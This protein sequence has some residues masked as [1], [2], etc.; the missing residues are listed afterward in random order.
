[1]K[2]RWRKREKGSRAFNAWLYLITFL[3]RQGDDSKDGAIKLKANHRREIHGFHFE[4]SI[5]HKFPSVLHHLLPSY[6]EQHVHAGVQNLQDVKT[7]CRLHKPIYRGVALET[8]ISNMYKTVFNDPYALP[9][10]CRSI[11]RIVL[12]LCLNNVL[13]QGRQNDTM[14]ITSTYFA[15]H[16]QQRPAR[17]LFPLHSQ[18][19]PSF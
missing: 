18:H 8:D 3:S 17:Y 9:H 16:R 10:V 2:H 15:W 7:V 4:V 11:A 12:F 1:M 6:L 19:L 13:W 14:P 5:K